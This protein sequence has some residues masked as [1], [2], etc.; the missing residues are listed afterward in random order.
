MKPDS[1]NIKKSEPVVNG[2]LVIQ[3]LDTDRLTQELEH[4]SQE[5]QPSQ[6]NETEPIPQPSV[7]HSTTSYAENNEKNLK[8]FNTGTKF[9]K[10]LAVCFRLSIVV[11]VIELF[12]FYAPV[13]GLLGPVIGF[14]AA[15]LIY[16]GAWVVSAAI[17][18]LCTVNVI[19]FII[20]RFIRRIPLSNAS[21]VYTAINL[22]VSVIFIIL[23]VQAIGQF[24]AS[25]QK[26]AEIDRRERSALSKEITLANEINASWKEIPGTEAI[27]KIRNCKVEDLYITDKTPKPWAIVDTDFK[28]LHR[29]YAPNPESFMADDETVKIAKSLKLP[30][31]PSDTESG[32]LES[33][34]MLT[35]GKVYI[36]I[37]PDVIPRYLKPDDY[38][39]WTGDNAAIHAI[40]DIQYKTNCKV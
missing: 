15:M 16:Q 13:L 29:A 26:S 28:V 6:L 34:Y 19:R 4:G 11:I 36:V 30:I 2:G 14:V 8:D 21:W 10:Y 1:D 20:L 27:Y 9:D 23:A 7:I 33:S 25:A 24:V 35:N 37:E 38:G 18:L 32:V 3:P 22:I 12:L 39:T 31:E 5:A 17:G 40:Q